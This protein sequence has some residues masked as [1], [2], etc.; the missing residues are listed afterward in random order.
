M[1]HEHC[2]N[3]RTPPSDGYWAKD[4]LVEAD[5]A[6]GRIACYKMTWIPNTMTKDCQQP[7]GRPPLPGCVGCRELGEN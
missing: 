6:E 3:N 5:T 2:W 4:G 7:G 1:K